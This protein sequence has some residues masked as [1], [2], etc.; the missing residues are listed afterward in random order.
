MPYTADMSNRITVPVDSSSVY[1]TAEIPSG[2]E[3]GF[4]QSYEDSIQD[5]QAS[6][7]DQPYV[8]KVLFDRPLTIMFHTQY[9]AG[10]TRPYL[11]LCDKYGNEITAYTAALNAAPFYKGF[12]IFP[13]ND[14]DGTPLLTSLWSFTFTDL[15]ITDGGIYFLRFRNFFTGQ[16]DIDYLSE[17][18]MVA[19]T[20][21]NIKFFE[22]GFNSNNA[23]KNIIVGNWFDDYPTNAVPYTPVFYLIAEAYIN[24][25]V[26]KVVNI[27]Y[28]KQNYEQVQIKTQ[29][30]TTYTLKVG[31]NEL[32]IPQYLLDKLTDCMTADLIQIQ[33]S[34]VIVY[35][36]SPQPTPSD[37]WKIIDKDVATLIRAS[38][39]IALVSEKQRAFVTPTPSLFGRIFDDEFDDTFA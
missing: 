27:G 22:F 10:S 25:F 5:W 3:V 32:G 7:S 29:K 17:P 28:Q 6:Y 37:L 9:D 31:E 24:L 33:G 2:L 12:Q 15:G 8:Q 35:N 34:P 26:P 16:A 38:V 1:F 30:I 19:I 23:D 14:F 18:L 20:H 39:V 21:R 4:Q 36:P 11:Y 13:N